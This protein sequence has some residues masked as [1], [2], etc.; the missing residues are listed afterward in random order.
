MALTASRRELPNEVRLSLSQFVLPSLARSIVGLCTFSLSLTQLNWWTGA[1]N[2]DDVG[3]SDGGGGG[4][5][6][7]GFQAPGS[8]VLPLSLV[9]SSGVT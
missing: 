9:A 2:D 1:P 6:C 5:G 7:V 3:G 8:V 4:G